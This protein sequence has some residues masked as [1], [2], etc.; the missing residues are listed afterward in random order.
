MEPRFILSLHLPGLEGCREDAIR[1][2][3][4]PASTGNKTGF[5]KQNMVGTA[6]L[7][8]HYESIA[9]LGCNQQTPTIS[10][11][12]AI[13]T[14][15]VTGMSVEQDFGNL[16]DTEAVNRQMRIPEVVNTTSTYGPWR[17]VGNYKREA[18]VCNCL[19]M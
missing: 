6:A 15:K 9:A 2:F 11:D 16:F 7:L 12:R 5:G 14:I 1:R 19:G 17:K 10:C 13:K 18:R 8:Q 4:R 3:N